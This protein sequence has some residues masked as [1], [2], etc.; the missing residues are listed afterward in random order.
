[1]VH[2]RLVYQ[3]G[4]GII[5]L[6]PGSTVFSNLF[7]RFFSIACSTHSLNHIIPVIVFVQRH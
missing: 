4:L 6:S 3:L 7:L 1:V 2:E 5:L